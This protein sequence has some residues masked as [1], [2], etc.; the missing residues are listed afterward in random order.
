MSL[1]YAEDSW[2]GDDDDDL[3]NGTTTTSNTTSPSLSHTNSNQ[4]KKQKSRKNTQLYRS[5]DDIAVD[6]YLYQN[7]RST[8]PDPYYSPG[9]LGS[10]G[11]DVSDSRYWDTEGTI[12]FIGLE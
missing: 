7:K 8:Q 5:D 9:I 1:N 6:P 2:S 12:E 3:E 10:P 4:T 11:K